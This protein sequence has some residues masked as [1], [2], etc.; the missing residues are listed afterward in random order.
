MIAINLERHANL[1]L[2]L[3][4]ATAT[5]MILDKEATNSDDLL[6]SLCLSCKRITINKQQTQRYDFKERY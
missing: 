5:D 2:A 1:I 6:D 4:T 3:R